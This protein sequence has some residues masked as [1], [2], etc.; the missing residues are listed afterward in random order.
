MGRLRGQAGAHSLDVR[1]ARAARAPGAAVTV[2]EAYTEVV[3]ITRREARNFAWGIALLPRP[4]RLAVAAL[5]AFAR[6][7]DDIADDPA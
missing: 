6:R 5:Y 7:V 3:R 1:A 4:K 2:R